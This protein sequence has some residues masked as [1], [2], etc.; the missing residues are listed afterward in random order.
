MLKKTHAILH[1]HHLTAVTTVM[2]S[3][4]ALSFWI[5]LC[6][7]TDSQVPTIPCCMTALTVTLSYMMALLKICDCALSAPY[8]PTQPNENAF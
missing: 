6:R 1:R 2:V 7:G 4:A 3:A 5:V 8:L